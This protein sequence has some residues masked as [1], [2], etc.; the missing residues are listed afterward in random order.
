MT[1]PKVL[2]RELLWS[3]SSPNPHWYGGAFLQLVPIKLFMPE[4][5][6]WGRRNVQWF[7]GDD[8]GT[9][10]GDS[11]GLALAIENIE[12]RLRALHSELSR[13]LEVTHGDT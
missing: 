12:N 9:C 3:G 13:A 1:T 5:G 11:D 7:V 10:S 2:G 4:L 6:M 8:S